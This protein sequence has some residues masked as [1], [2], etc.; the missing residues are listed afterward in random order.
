MQFSS[1]VGTNIP[2]IATISDM[3][4]ACCAPAF[5]DKDSQRKHHSDLLVTCISSRR[6]SSAADLHSA[7]NF[8]NSIGYT[9]TGCSQ[10][11]IAVVMKRHNDV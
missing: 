3:L 2:L 6:F 4:N 9:E 5:R 10:I 11:L 1:P 8:G 7:Q